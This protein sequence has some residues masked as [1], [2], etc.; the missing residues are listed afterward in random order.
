MQDARS[1]TAIE[2]ASQAGPAMACHRNQ[3]CL[4]SLCYFENRVH[5]RTHFNEK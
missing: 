2:G 1:H 5:D 3:I 4:L